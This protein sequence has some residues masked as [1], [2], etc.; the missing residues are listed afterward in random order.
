MSALGRE[1]PLSLEMQ[2]GAA[3]RQFRANSG[4]KKAP[5]LIEAWQVRC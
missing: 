5:R 4:H 1:L 2:P 3:Q